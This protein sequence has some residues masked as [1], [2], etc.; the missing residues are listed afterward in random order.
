[1]PAGSGLFTTFTITIWIRGHSNSRGCC[2]SHGNTTQYIS[3]E[4]ISIKRMQRP[5]GGSISPDS[6]VARSIKGSPFEKWARNVYL[7]NGFAIKDKAKAHVTLH[8]TYIHKNEIF[9]ENWK[10]VTSSSIKIRSL[11]VS[12]FC[13]TSG[14][15]HC[16]YFFY[17]THIALHK[18]MKLHPTK[19]FPWLFPKNVYRQ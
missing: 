1:M 11:H 4:T 13:R 12:N 6:S 19:P 17:S 18:V 9:N 5:L 7:L 15:F 8:C 14:Y 16:W 3:M 2:F 10:A